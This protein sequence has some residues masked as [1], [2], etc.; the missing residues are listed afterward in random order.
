MFS[1]L[2]CSKTFNGQSVL[3]MIPRLTRLFFNNLRY[4]TQPNPCVNACLQSNIGQ[5]LL[6][7]NTQCFLQADALKKVE[8]Q[9]LF[10]VSCAVWKSKKGKAA[11]DKFKQIV[12][13]RDVE[14]YVDLITFENNLKEIVQQLQDDLSKNFRIGGDLSVFEQIAVTVD[15][16][17]VNLSDVGLI[18]K[19][20]PRLITIDMYAYPELI[21][22]IKSAL[23]DS[24]SNI[25]LSVTGS[26]IKVQVSQATAE[27]RRDLVKKVKARVGVCKSDL[28][29]M[30]TQLTN[31]TFALEGVSVDV[32]KNLSEQLK[33]YNQH[34]VSK[35]DQIFK[36]KEAALLN[37]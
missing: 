32:K 12:N 29:T 6:H 3:E 8:N 10:S 33:L 7:R 23:Q 15:N 24:L 13:P 34:Y 9:R 14:E 17:H 25:N 2:F 21:P 4:L 27:Y 28:H 20:S 35:V 36:N 5:H 31:S 16:E 30:V 19:A 37:P 22:Q 26:I 1:R 11:A 18:V